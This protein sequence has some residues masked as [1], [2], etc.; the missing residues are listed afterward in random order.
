MDS[1]PQKQDKYVLR[2]EQDGHRD[3]LKEMATRGKRSLNKQIL[4]LIEL[5]E[6]S[7]EQGRAAA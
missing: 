6:E 7:T 4:L 3:R 5:G 1:K 2:F